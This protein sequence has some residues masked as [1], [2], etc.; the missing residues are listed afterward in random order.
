MYQKRNNRFEITSLYLT[1]YNKQF[2]IREISR[3]T[4]IPLKTTYTTIKSKL[5]I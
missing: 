5:K 4:K 3:L 1:D 2:Y